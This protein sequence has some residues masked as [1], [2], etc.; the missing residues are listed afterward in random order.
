MNA[1]SVWNTVAG[2]YNFMPYP[3]SPTATF[4]SAYFGSNFAADSAAITAAVNASLTAA[5]PTVGQGDLMN[6][7]LLNW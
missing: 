2:L 3:Q 5:R 4:G 7:T 6:A 1:T